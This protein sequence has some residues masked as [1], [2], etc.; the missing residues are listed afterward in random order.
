[1][2]YNETLK[3]LAAWLSALK[4]AAENDETFS[5]SWFNGTK[6]YPFSIIGGWASGFSDCYADLLCVSKSEPE[7]AMCIKIVVNEGPY[8]Y[9]DYEVMN[10][11][12]DEKTGNVDDTEVALEWVDDTES[13]AGWLMCEWERIMK[14]HGEEV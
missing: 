14:E 2:N 4:A 10:M 9:T 5:I 8:A 12:Y 11:P 13:L 3:D 1:M 7:Y 6:D